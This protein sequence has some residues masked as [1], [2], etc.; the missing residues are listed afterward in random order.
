MGCRFSASPTFP[1]PGGWEVKAAAIVSPMA[2]AASSLDKTNCVPPAGAN[3]P[4]TPDFPLSI[5]PNHGQIHQYK[6]TFFDW[7]KSLRNQV[8]SIVTVFLSQPR[9]GTAKCCYSV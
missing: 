4:A 2:E 1:F 8:P 3:L 6:S 7:R 5:L 9:E